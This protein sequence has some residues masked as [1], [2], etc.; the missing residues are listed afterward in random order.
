QTIQQ[1]PFTAYRAEA[2]LNQAKALL[3]LGD[4]QAA[5]DCLYHVVDGSRG[6]ALEPT[7]YLY[8]GRIFLDDGDVSQAVRPL[9]RSAELAPPQVQAVAATTLAATYLLADN[10]Q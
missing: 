1:H 2:W 9:L 7:A 6:H 5:R 3:R 4:T 8:L 10:P